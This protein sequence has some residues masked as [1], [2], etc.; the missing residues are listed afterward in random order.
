MENTKNNIT[1]NGNVTVNVTNNA[2]TPTDTNE[3]NFTESTTLGELLKLL[4][5]GEKPHEIP[6]PKKLR[7]N[8]GKPI[9]FY[10]MSGSMPVENVK[11]TVYSNGFAV[12]DNGSGRTVLWLPDCTSFTYIF[13]KPKASEEGMMPYKEEIP[14]EMLE[15]LSWF[16][17]VTLIGDHRVENNLMNRKSGRSMSVNYDAYDYDDKHYADDDEKDPYR[18][19]F[20][21]TDGRFG[22]NPLDALIREERN[23]E[24]LAA[25]TDKQREVFLLYYKDGYTQQQIADMLDVDQTSVR[26]RLDGGLKKIKKFF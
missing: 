17:A 21:W 8:A 14:D 4:N 3:I 25:M 11:C 1:I 6:T 5:L 2:I 16:T 23:R 19:A 20:F 10:P 24:I 7:E 26:D 15:S 12:Y 9:A 18:G 22:E 13:A